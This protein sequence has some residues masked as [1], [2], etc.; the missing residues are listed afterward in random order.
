M[1]ENELNYKQ[2][3]LNF[4][5]AILA[6]LA[7][8]I[9]TILSVYRYELFGIEPGYAPHN[10]G[11]NVTYI[12]PSILLILILCLLVLLRT[13]IYW[14]RYLNKTKKI[15]ALVISLSIWTYEIFLIAWIFIN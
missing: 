13:L 10:F 7:F 8:I 14:R 12:F 11:F 9:V 5:L 4:A 3:N 6:L 2:G 15:I 1:G